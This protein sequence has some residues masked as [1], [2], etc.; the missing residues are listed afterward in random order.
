[1]TFDPC[2]ALTI[3]P[4]PATDPGEVQSVEDAVLLWSRV[5]PTRITVGEESP[6]AP[7]V[8]IVFESGDN[9]Y[10]ATYW[11]QLGAISI[12]R[13]RLDRADYPVVI[14]HE[15][16]HAF[17]LPHVSTDVRPSVMN[18]GNLE[19]EPNDEDASPLRERWA[20][21]AGEPTGG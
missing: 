16:G 14:A 20:T 13:D 3:V 12:S 11:D 9:F 4:I 7:V 17:G 1:M 19:I 5:L 21:C 18:V 10:R 6:E 15:L 2:S 8:K